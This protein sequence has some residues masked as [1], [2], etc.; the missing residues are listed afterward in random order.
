MFMESIDEVKEDVQIGDVGEIVGRIAYILLENSLRMRMIWNE[1][2]AKGGIDGRLK[3]L[4]LNKST[5]SA[6][7]SATNFWLFPRSSIADAH[8]LGCFRNA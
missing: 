3:R 6:I 4:A 1:E 5:M 2:L 8:A 7:F